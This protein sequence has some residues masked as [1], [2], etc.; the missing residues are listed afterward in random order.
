MRATLLALALL[1][2]TVFA[3]ITITGPSAS[4]YW[5]QNTSNI[6]SWSYTSGDPTSV[7]IIVTNSDNQT[8]N[9]AFSI[10]RGVPVSQESFT[11]TDVTLRVGT[12]YRVAFLDPV[13]DNQ[14]FAQSS[15]FEVKV[16][17]T[18]P[19][20]T[21]TTNPTAAASGSGSPSGTGTPRQHDCYW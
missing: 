16:P 3:I 10:A 4:S 11:V 8:L 1:P 6:I 12:G 20:P 5:V 7:D 18:P 2:S 15:D 9:G 14:T 17:G 19:A 21:A 13:N